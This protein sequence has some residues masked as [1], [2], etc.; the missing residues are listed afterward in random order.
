MSEENVKEMY[1]VEIILEW[2]SP[3]NNSAKPEIIAYC[4]AL[5]DAQAIFDRRVE[6]ALGEKAIFEERGGY[7]TRCIHVYS[8]SYETILQRYF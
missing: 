5:S 8:S 3:E 6:K 2:E 1:R 4:K 7:K